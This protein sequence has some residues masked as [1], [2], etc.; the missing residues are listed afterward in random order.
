MY[1]IISYE[2]ELNQ[3]CYNFLS[4]FLSNLNESNAANHI[5]KII[6][7]VKLCASISKNTLDDSSLNT[8]LLNMNV[9]RFNVGFES[10]KFLFLACIHFHIKLNSYDK[11]YTKKFVL[12]EKETIEKIKQV[13]S[14]NISLFFLYYSDSIIKIIKDNYDL[15]F[16]GINQLMNPSAMFLNIFSSKFDLV[17]SYFPQLGKCDILCLCSIIQNDSLFNEIFNNGT[18]KLVLIQT[19][20]KYIKKHKDKSLSIKNELFKVNLNFNYVNSDGEKSDNEDNEENNYDN[21]FNDKVNEIIKMHSVVENN[22]EYKIF[23]ETINKIKISDEN[24][25]NELIR[26]LDDNGQKVLSELINIRNVNIEMNGI[27]YQVPRRRL[28]IIRNSS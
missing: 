10:L 28:K 19:L 16:N 24:L 25:F 6:S 17:Y 11:N 21:L 20:I 14:C 13:L 7:I 4:V 15:I 9:L 26:G 18:R 3:Y 12:N 27:K 5:N 23:A 22:D 8:L 2:K 1:T